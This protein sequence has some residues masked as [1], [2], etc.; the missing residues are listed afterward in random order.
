MFTCIKSSFTLFV[1]RS[2][3]KVVSLDLTNT[4]SQIN[5]EY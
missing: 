5:N 3:V 2:S 4:S 1:F